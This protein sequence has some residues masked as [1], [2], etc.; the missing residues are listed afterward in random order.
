[1]HDEIA[2]ISEDIEAYIRLIDDCASYD[3]RVFFKELNKN[4]AKLYMNGLLLA[5]RY[6]RAEVA[7]WDE[8]DEEDD[9][10]LEEDETPADE[11]RLERRYAIYKRA[12][13]KLTTYL[14][15]ADTYNL[16]QP[17]P[18]TEDE[19]EEAYT[20]TLSNDLAEIYEDLKEVLPELENGTIDSVEFVVRFDHWGDHLTRAL[21]I[22]HNL[23][24]WYDD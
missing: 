11:E 8:E 23:L 16:I 22:V 7:T 5:D 18:L 20:T 17:Y 1:M 12:E 13:S 6:D 4:M 10:Y 3:Q 21:Y 24:S 19:P 9:S 14:G 2:A 15:A